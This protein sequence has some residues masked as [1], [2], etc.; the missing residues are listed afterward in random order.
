MLRYYLGLDNDEVAAELGVTAGAARTPISRGL[1]ALRIAGAD[2]NPST[3]GTTRSADR[4]D[5]V[6][7]PAARRPGGF[8]VSSARARSQEG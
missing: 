7:R 2:E 1:A 3:A 5:D 4:A 8:H 6:S